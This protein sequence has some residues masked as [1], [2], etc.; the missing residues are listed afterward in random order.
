MVNDS[1]QAPALVEAVALVLG[2][3]I[4]VVLPVH[5]EEAAL[6]GLIDEI[7]IALA[8][9]KFEIV[10][11][12]D[13]STDGSAARLDALGE[14]RHWLRVYRHDRNRGQTAALETGIGLAAGAVIVLL[15]SDGQNDPQDIPRLVGELTPEVDIVAGRRRGRHENARR[16][17]ASRAANWLLRRASGVPVHDTGCTLK[18]FRAET[19]KGLRLLRGDHRF[20]PALARTD[21]ERVREIWV[22]DRPRLA[23]RSHYGFGRAPIVAAD[24]L[25]LAVRRFVPQRPLHSAAAAALLLLTLWLVLAAVLVAFGQLAAAVVAVM[26]GVSLAV[27]AV[28]L[29]TALEGALRG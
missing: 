8:G 28:V 21:T 9:R 25:G 4:T 3:E 26:A 1:L 23:G 15:D 2:P 22:A 18:A 20:L 7:E 19:L 5:N 27:I 16:R 17:I 6:A 29:A 13:G 14:T 24:L 10:A 12:D 11:V